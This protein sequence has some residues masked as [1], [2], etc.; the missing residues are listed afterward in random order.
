MYI[1]TLFLHLTLKMHFPS[2][3][4]LTLQLH[5]KFLKSLEPIFFSLLVKSPVNASNRLV[6][7]W[8]DIEL[9]NHLILNFFFNLFIITCIS[10][11]SFHVSHDPMQKYIYCLLSCLACWD[12]FFHLALSFTSFSISSSVGNLL[13]TNHDL[14]GDSAC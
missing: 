9:R 2:T 12:V 4:V 3:L 6:N 10:C 11:L 13:V 1:T 14:I 8:Y 7:L 5:G